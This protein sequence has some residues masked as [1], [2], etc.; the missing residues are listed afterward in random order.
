MAHVGFLGGFFQGDI[1]A[2]STKT[3]KE[4]GWTPTHRGLLADIDSEAYFPA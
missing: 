2:S 3:Q 4:L 1:P